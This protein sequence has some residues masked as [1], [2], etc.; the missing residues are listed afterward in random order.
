MHPHTSPNDHRRYHYFV[1]ANQ[2]KVLLIEDPQTDKS[3]ASLAVQVGHFSDPADRQGMAHFLEHMLF[4]GTAT[5]PEPGEY[6]S[7]IQRHGGSNNA[8]TGTEFTNFFFDLQHEFFESGLARF[9]QFFI[10]P[11]FDAALV[12][13]ERQAVDSEYRLKYKDE[14]RR[15]YQVHKE[16]VNPD[17]PF[18][19]FSVGNLQTLDDRPGTELRDELI[20]FYRRHYSADR[21][22]LV[23]QSPYSLAQQAAWVEQYFSAVPNQQL[24]VAAPW[25]PLYLPAQL[26][27]RV[28]I[29]PIKESRKLTVT[30]PLQGVE[31]HY[32]SKPLTFLSHLLGDE[33]PGSLYAYLKRQGWV[34]TL[35]AGGGL[36]G[37]DFKD[38][39]V[40]FGLTRD[41]LHQEGTIIECLF[42]CLALIRQQ[43]LAAWRY[44]EKKQVLDAIYRYQEGIRAIDNVSHLAMN[45]FHYP[46]EDVV[47]GDYLMEGFDAG[48]VAHYLEQLTPDNM[49]VQL[50]SPQA[51]TDRQAAW[52]DTPY[53]VEP[54]DP[55]WL[56]LWRQPR[57]EL[58]G[59]GL[60][61]PPTNP[62]ICQELEPQ[63]VHAVYHQPQRLVGRPGLRLWH[64]HDADFRVPKG[65][66]F[67]AVD[68]EH[69]VRSN[70]HIATMRLIVELWLD[71]LNELTYAAGMAG[72][73]YHA[74]A[75]QGGYTLQLGG[76][77]APQA[78]LLELILKHRTFGRVDPQRFA[79]IKQQLTQ[80]WENQLKGR[81]IS[82][83]FNHLT[84]VLQPNNPPVEDLLPQ[85][86]A[87]SQE[88]LP[89]FVQQLYK[90][91]HLEVLAHGDWT[92]QQVRE[93]A[94]L[95]E[96]E[97][98]PLSLPSRETRRAL[99][100]LRGQGCL[101]RQRHCPHQDSAVLIYYQSPGTSPQD[102]AHFTLA[103]HLMG[104]VFF[105]QLRTEQQLG[106]VVG[107]GTLPL[108]RHP[109]LI[110][111]VQSPVAGPQ[112]L[113]DAMDTFI[114]DFPASLQAMSDDEWQQSKAGLISQLA[115]KDA[116]LRSRSQRLWVCVGG[117][118]FS[119]DQK[120]Q[121]ARYL[122]QISRAQMLRFLR[123]LR[124]S[125]ADRLV[126]FSQ[127]EAHQ[128]ED[129][130]AEGRYID[131]LATFRQT[132]QY[133]FN[134]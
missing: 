58:L 84:S 16:T 6:Q 57:L 113:L 44:D 53:R 19:K 3:A 45:L 40:S 118:D 60:A 4:L 52:Y 106:Y 117:R 26:G 67:I 105:H 31:Q 134:L 1:L 65:N 5:Y 76:F 82:L 50:V 83:L 71:H 90:A 68:S 133:F 111:Y 89:E 56:K 115:E 102:I 61:L 46:P 22:S 79:L 91:V 126:L 9:A 108:N 23:L 81:P 107:T 32:R 17:H 74:Y 10:C 80:S 15:V 55:I 122:E 18:A 36:S 21:M 87:I 33:G 34:T 104:P 94:G 24:G 72:L 101:L 12:D 75:H 7:F 85:L 131:D 96:R 70:R 49:R 119:F 51:K 42:A 11:T 2:L 66:L 112:A 13:K 124:A 97:L 114:D 62:F 69:A 27:I 86:E 98:T 48:L 130:M 103:N 54:L 78:R 64:L 35:S 116:N 38:F 125:F 37:R 28:E 93:I 77:S 59:Q 132:S 92:E 123:K 47:R 25:P 8:W 127:G 41:G 109:G 121:V 88:Q 99:V 95:L 110:L 73:N 120:E 30:F 29:K 20:A 128:A 129:P 100:D 43:G 39:C 14:V 63:T